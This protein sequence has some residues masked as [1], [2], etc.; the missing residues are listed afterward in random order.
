MSVGL[1]KPSVPIIWFILILSF[2]QQSYGQ[3]RVIRIRID[4]KYVMMYAYGLYGIEG[5]TWFDKANFNLAQFGPAVSI[6]QHFGIEYSY[7]RSFSVDASGSFQGV[8]INPRLT[9]HSATL[10]YRSGTHSSR[11]RFLVTI[12]HGWWQVSQTASLDPNSFIVNYLS[13]DASDFDF[14][15]T[16]NV[17]SFSAGVSLLVG[18]HLLI[19][20]LEITIN[21]VRGSLTL[22]EFEPVCL[23][24]GLGYQFRWKKK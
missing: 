24:A 5:R 11:W 2:A 23:K 13:L 9:A 21:N 14:S 12:G 4:L 22:Y 16:V 17:V 7:S 20:P 1:T 18:K 19:Y 3:E 15:E 6:G 8:K 10:S